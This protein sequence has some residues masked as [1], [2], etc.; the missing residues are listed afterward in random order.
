MAL[1]V[2]NGATG[3]VIQ[4][5]GTWYAYDSN[6]IFLPYGGGTFTVTLGTTQDDVTHIDALRCAPTSCP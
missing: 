1:N 5:A 6:S 3:Q 2:T 4:N